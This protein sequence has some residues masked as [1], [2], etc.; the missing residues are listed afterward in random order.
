MKEIAPDGF[1]NEDDNCTK[2]SEKELK[3]DDIV[4]STLHS[5]DDEDVKNRLEMYE[6]LFSYRY[7]ADDAEYNACV[8][9][10]SVPPPCVENWYTHPKR[11]FDWTQQRGYLT[12]KFLSSS[13]ISEFKL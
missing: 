2:Q 3:D 12:N 11:S 5:N 13:P 9:S 10:P 1:I 7:T 8:N 6:Q 4:A